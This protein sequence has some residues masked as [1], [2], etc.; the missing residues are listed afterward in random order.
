VTQPSPLALIATA[1]AD[2]PPLGRRAHA[3]VFA[4][5][6]AGLLR[7]LAEED[8]RTALECSREWAALTIAYLIGNTVELHDG[9]LHVDDRE[10]PAGPGSAL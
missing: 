10:W 8:G 1:L 6:G 3:A 9:R 4:A 2:R 7:V 5:Y